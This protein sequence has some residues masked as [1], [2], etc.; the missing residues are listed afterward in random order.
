MDLSWLVFR[1][2]GAAYCE[3]GVDWGGCAIGHGW[4]RLGGLCGI[5]VG[6]VPGVDGEGL[7][8]GLVAWAKGSEGDDGAGRWDTGAFLVIGRELEEHVPFGL[9]LD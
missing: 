5:E 9:G 7:G 4:S 1:G 6:G 2:G 8:W 3:V